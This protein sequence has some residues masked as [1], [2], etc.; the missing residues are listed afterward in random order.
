MTTPRRTPTRSGSQRSLLENAEPVNEPAPARR[1]SSRTPS[2]RNIL[3]PSPAVQETPRGRG[4]SRTGS[5]RVLGTPR[6]RARNQAVRSQSSPPPPNRHN[7]YVPPPPKEDKE[8]LPPTPQYIYVMMSFETETVLGTDRYDIVN[9]HHAAANIKQVQSTTQFTVE[10]K[11]RG[12]PQKPIK[13]HLKRKGKGKDKGKIIIT[14]FSATTPNLI[15]NPSGLQKKV[16]DKILVCLFNG[17]YAF[18]FVGVQWFFYVLE[19]FQH[20]P[21][22]KVLK[23]QPAQQY[24]V[25]GDWFNDTFEPVDDDQREA[26]FRTIEAY[27][28]VDMAKKFHSSGKTSFAD[29]EK[30]SL[31]LQEMPKG[32]QSEFVTRPAAP[33]FVPPLSGVASMA[34]MNQGLAQLQFLQARDIST[35]LSRQMDQNEQFQ[36]QILTQGER[37]MKLEERQMEHGKE[38]V[39][40]KKEQLAQG[41]QIS[42]QGAQISEQGSQLNA[43]KNRVDQLEAA[44]A[45]TAGN[46]G[47]N[48]NNFAAPPAAAGSSQSSATTVGDEEEDELK[49]AAVGDDEKEESAPTFFSILGFGK[50]K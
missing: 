34:D 21:E 37:Q 3:D 30:Y 46:G 9:L 45:D 7:Q 2:R 43:L 18:V 26:M 17:K 44:K 20:D 19:L 27:H 48:N 42:G 41:A 22:H 23:G 5:N 33:A 47:S 36:G 32:L 14:G 38:I 25:F 1:T 4:M 40:L 11:A 16:G 31:I 29:S 15:A 24:E 6:P 13:W 8:P 28:V 35:I 10:I 12:D 39:G 50:K 49:P